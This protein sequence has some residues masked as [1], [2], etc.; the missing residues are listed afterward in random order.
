VQEYVTELRNASA[1]LD[2]ENPTIIRNFRMSLPAEWIV[3]SDGQ[4]MSVKTD[5]LAAALLAEEIAPKGASDPSKKGRQRLVA[6][7][8][9]A[10]SLL[11]PANRADLEQSRAQVDKI[12]RDR[13]FQ[14]SH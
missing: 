6:L 10:E 4:A 2:S 14:G 1:A 3:S 8:E 9:A 13:E 12:L 11:S 7:R 5:W